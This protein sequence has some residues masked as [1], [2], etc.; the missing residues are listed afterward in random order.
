[1]AT[2]QVVLS[3]ERLVLGPWT[4]EDATAGLAIFG[5]R[6]VTHWLIPPME[7]IPDEAAMRAAIER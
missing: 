1:M 6:E 4:V 7:P 2:R 5:R 3:T